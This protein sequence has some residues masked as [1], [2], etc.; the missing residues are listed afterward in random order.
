MKTDVILPR[1]FDRD[2]YHVLQRGIA[3]SPETT[4]YIN[5]RKDFAFLS[6]PPA[7]DYSA[8]IPRVK[9]F[10]LT[11]YKKKLI[12]DE[13]RYPQDRLIGCPPRL[14]PRVI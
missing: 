4:V 14:R 2:E 11:A 7:V 10:N 13:R 1:P 12:I 9:K 6:P 5:T 3:D 8:Y